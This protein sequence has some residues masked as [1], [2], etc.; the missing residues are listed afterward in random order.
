MITKLKPRTRAIA[1]GVVG[2]LAVRSALKVL[3]A[4]GGSVSAL[5]YMTLGKLLGVK[6]EPER[7]LGRL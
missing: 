1:V 5:G 2:L 4:T 3:L 6:F 7:P